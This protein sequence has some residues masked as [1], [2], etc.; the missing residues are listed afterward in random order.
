[1]N[2]RFLF[3][4][5]FQA[6][7]FIVVCK[8]V[9]WFFATKKKDAT[10][11]DWVWSALFIGIALLYGLLGDGSQTR[12][13][14]ITILVCLWSLRLTAYLWFRT[15][16]KAEE[17]RYR[18]LREQWGESADLRF[19]AFFLLQG[20]TALLL[21][22]PFAVICLNPEPLISPTEALGVA[23]WIFGFLGEALADQQLF[24]FKRSSQGGG[25]LN[26]GLWKYSRHPN[27]FF[28]W[29]IW[30]GYSLIALGSHWGWATLYCP[31]LVYY[32]LTRVTGIPVTETQAE[33]SRGESY[34]KYVRK[35]NAFFPW[36]PKGN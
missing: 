6:A 19:L 12:R 2:H 35:T 23:V 8:M 17:P 3:L 21:S 27:Y 1:M 9:S 14:M 26:Q 11:V 25:V 4:L 22:I 30:C 7:L 18:H 29:M 24:E 10:L 5:I 32:L 15:R 33:R 31:I 28:E 13:W 16:G 20:L 36:F 34:L